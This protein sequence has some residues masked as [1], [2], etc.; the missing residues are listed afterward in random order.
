MNSSP[1]IRDSMS[2]FAQIQPEP[3]CDLYQKRIPDRVAVIVVDVLEIVDVE[4]RER[5]LAL[6]SVALQKAVGA[7]FNHAPR[8]QVGQLVIIS[9]P[10]QLIFDGL[11]L[12]DVSRAR[13]QQFAICD[14]N[15]PMDREK[16]LLC[17]AAGYAFFRDR[18]AAGAEQFKPGFATAV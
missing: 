10:E 7:T 6:R 12:A 18:G 9:R 16:D 11:L 8:R 4:K 1:L 2:E 15:R 14:P 3:L 13:K 17:L 5:E